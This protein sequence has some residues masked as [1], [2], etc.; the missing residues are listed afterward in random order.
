LPDLTSLD[1]DGCQQITD[2]HLAKLPRLQHLDMMECTGISDAAFAFMP[3]LRTLK[4]I[5][6]PQVSQWDESMW[7]RLPRLE[8]VI[9]FL[10]MYPHY[11]RIKQLLESRGV[12]V[13]AW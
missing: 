8:M 2:A 3:D 11:E 1:I 10:G 6:C 12:I 4:I 13:F 9:M 7:T 5:D